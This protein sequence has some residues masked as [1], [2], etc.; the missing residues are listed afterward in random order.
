MMSKSEFEK[1]AGQ[2]MYYPHA[3]HGHRG[4]LYVQTTTANYI[5]LISRGCLLDLTGR[6][7]IGPCTYIAAGV[8]VWTHKHNIAS[9]EILLDRKARM[10]AEFTIPLDKVIMDDVWIY[11][12][13]IL[14]GCRMI[15]T[16]VV[17]GAGSVVTHSITEPWSIWG[18]N[19]AVKIGSRQNFAKSFMVEV[20]ENIERMDSSLK[21]GEKFNPDEFERLYEKNCIKEKIIKE[22]L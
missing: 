18:G 11:E 2:V 21:S 4:D 6:L 12:S 15:A 20:M 8:K 17:I 22:V 9:T 14:P 7:F 3:D 19:P 16:G 5:C 10:G 13:L 1:V